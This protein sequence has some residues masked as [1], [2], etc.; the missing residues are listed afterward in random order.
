MKRGKMGEAYGIISIKGGVGK[1]TSVI[2]LGAVLAKEFGKRVLLVDANF[3]APNLALHIGCINL[4][5]TIHDVLAG[6]AEP[7]EA[8]YD[9]EY[10]FHIMPGALLYNKVNPYKLRQKIKKIKDYYDVILID[11]SPSLNEEILTTMIASDKLFVITTPDHVTLSTTLRAVKLA[12]EKN[13]QIDGLIINKVYNKKFELRLEDI[14]KACDTP[15]LAVIEHDTSFLEALSKNI[16]PTLHKLNNAT[17]E[18]AKLASA[19]IGDVYSDPRILP[20]LKNLFWK[21]TK[22]QEQNR[23]KFRET[24]LS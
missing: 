3:S 14:E 2:A 5:K 6:K 21:T 11:S 8:I 18:Y 22:K 13:T 10:G 19:I 17:I 4:D 7:E 23:D 9:T 24:L 20:K 15:V 16:P 12:K 1:T